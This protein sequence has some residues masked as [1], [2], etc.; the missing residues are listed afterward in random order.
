MGKFFNGELISLGEVAKRWN[1]SINT[2]ITTLIEVA[3][4]HKDKQDLFAFYTVESKRQDAGLSIYHEINECA[5]DEAGNVWIDVDTKR[6]VLYENIL[7]KMESINISEKDREYLR[8][9][10]TLPIIKE[11]ISDTPCEDEDKDN[12]KIKDLSQRLYQE[13]NIN[14]EL[15]ERIK[16]LEAEN[17]R[18]RKDIELKE[19]KSRVDATNWEE[20]VKTVLQT[21]VET[22]T[23]EKGEMEKWKYDDFKKVCQDNNRYCLTKVI[24]AAWGK[25]PDKYKLGGG[26][27]RKN[28]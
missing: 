28:S 20:S 14:I 1:C 11:Y 18:L 4:N 24:N 27:P 23:S 7:V 26:R 9:C 19:P 8:H 25:L 16:H 6:V 17:E 12:S 2:V 15:N 13:Q 10:I 5:W 3:Q 21:V 22:L